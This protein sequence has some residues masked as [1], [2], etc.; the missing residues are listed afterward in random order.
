MTVAFTL[1]DARVTARIVNLAYRM[2]ARVERIRLDARGQRFDAEFKFGGE[3]ETLRRLDS[4][5]ARL[6]SDETVEG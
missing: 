2:G 5:L 1:T 4:Q 6:V 3:H